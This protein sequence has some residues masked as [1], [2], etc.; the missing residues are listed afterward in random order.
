MIRA[1][2]ARVAVVN[3]PPLRRNKN[4]VQRRTQERATI[5]KYRDMLRE[6]QRF[7]GRK[8]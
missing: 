2:V 5:G 1:D 8:D 3:Y 6:A 4:V 7:K